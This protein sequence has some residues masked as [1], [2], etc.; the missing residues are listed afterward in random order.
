MR[1]DGE[2]TLGADQVRNLGKVTVAAHGFRAAVLAIA[3]GAGLGAEA[4]SR[5]DSAFTVGSYPVDAE[6]SDA[7]RAKAKALAD[8]QQA[9]LRAL[10]KRIV[11][12]TAYPR[13]KRLA[14]TK[15]ADLADGYAVRSE[16]NSSTRYIATL[17]FSFQPQA[18]RDLLRREG[19]PYV[20]EQ[21]PAVVLVPILREAG[22][23]KGGQWSEAWKGL[24]TE[25]TLT[26]VKLAGL[27]PEIHQDTVR[28]ALEGQGGADRIL[29]QE[30]GSELVVLAVAEID[31]ATGKLTVTYAGNDAV[32]P[33]LWKRS[34]RIA[35][36]DL[37]YTMELASVIGLGVIEGRWKAVKARFAGAEAGPQT[38]G[39]AFP[40]GGA[41]TV[42]M[43]VEFRSLAQWND[44][45]G[46]ILDMPGVDNVE[47]GGI[48]ARAAD[49]SLSY[50]GGARQLAEDMAPKGMMLRNVGGTWVLRSSF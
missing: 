33:I 21:A 17:D 3:L 7:V 34:L 35:G 32:G 18:V 22:G 40:A 11:P 16:R 41:E 30:Y 13:L 6:A 15:A 48:S 24:D 19:V 1:G 27:K 4:A 14:G 38:G 8:G 44:I 31:N 46:Q 29:A 26:P 28:Q 23:L 37:V 45:R 49:V 10:F 36:G 50:P 42:T 47:V 25:H 43:Q 12:V 2:A 9:A 5:S 39:G 20:D